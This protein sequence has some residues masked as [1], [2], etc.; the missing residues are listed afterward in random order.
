M[1][2]RPWETMTDADFEAMLAR[3]VPDTVAWRLRGRRCPGRARPV[4]ILF[5]MALCAIT[6]NFWCLNYILPAIGTVLLLSFRALRFRLL[7]GSFPV[8]ADPRNCIPRHPEYDDFALRHRAPAVTT[9]LT[10]INAV[11]LLAL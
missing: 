11:L 7:G 5:G 4:R 1:C 8:S 2:D 3:S 10:V 9:T 6:L